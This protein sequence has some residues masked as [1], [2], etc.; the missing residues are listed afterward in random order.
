VP[1]IVGHW[2][3]EMKQP[4]HIGRSSALIRRTRQQKNSCG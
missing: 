1:F 4:Q 3:V 2:A